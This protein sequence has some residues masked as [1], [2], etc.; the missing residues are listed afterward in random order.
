MLPET[1]GRLAAVPN[2]VGVKEATGDLSR[3]EKIRALAG[4]ALRSTVATTPPRGS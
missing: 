2:I 1:V 3:V 4:P